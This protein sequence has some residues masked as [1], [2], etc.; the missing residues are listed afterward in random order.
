MKTG[1]VVLAELPQVDGRKKVRPALLLKQMPGRG[2]WL[3]CGISTRHY[4]FVEGF[5]ILLDAKHP[6]FSSSGLLEPSIIRLGF[7]AVLPTEHLKGSIGD[8]SDNTYQKIISTLT[9]YLLKNQ[10]G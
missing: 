6:D 7:L 1:Q 2:H 10:V 3:V 4:E 8:I 5:D 9:L